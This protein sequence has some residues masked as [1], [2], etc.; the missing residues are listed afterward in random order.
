MA[1]VKALE[2]PKCGAPV[3]FDQTYFKESK[4][5]RNMIFIH[6]NTGTAKCPNCQHTLQLEKDGEYPLHP[7]SITTS[8]NQK[9]RDNTAV[10]ISIGGDASGNFVVGNNNTVNGPTCPYCHEAVKPN[11]KVCPNCEAK[12]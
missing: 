5:G 11:W 1:K 3:N 8:I 4:D 2:C 10:S 7:T 9:G 6:A 12:L